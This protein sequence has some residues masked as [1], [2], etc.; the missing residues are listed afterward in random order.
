MG[1]VGE[2]GRSCLLY[3]ANLSCDNTCTVQQRFYNDRTV[4][5]AAR[6]QGAG[7]RRWQACSGHEPGVLAQ[8]AAPVLLATACLGCPHTH[9]PRLAI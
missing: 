5:R 1:W 7:S 8:V 4:T 3:I 9:T 6:Y 2:R